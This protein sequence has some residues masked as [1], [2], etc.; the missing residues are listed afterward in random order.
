MQKALRF[1][2]P[3]NVSVH[4]QPAGLGTRFVAWF[5]DQLLLWV[6][7]FVLF[8]GLMIAG[9]SFDFVF[10]TNRGHAHEDRALLYFVGLMMLIWGL[11]SIA[12]FGCC[13]LL[14][15]GQ[16]IGKR[17]SNIRVIKANG[18]QL[19]AGSVLV[20]NLFRVIDHLPPMWLFPII[21]RLGQRSGDM[22]AGTIVV[23]DQPAN[24]SSVRS[25]LATRQ[26]AD[27]QFRFDMSLLKR[28]NGNDFLAI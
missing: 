8:I 17:N 12:Y 4:Y 3:E 26:P 18:F 21:S 7:M 20:R 11:G 23:F 2:T 14:F 6:C 25:Q 15:R 9:F 16:T 10:Q 27:A 28:L 24:L 22:V 1:E 19:D 13:E 5:V